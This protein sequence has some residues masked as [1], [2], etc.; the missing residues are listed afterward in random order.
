MCL[1]PEL[2]YVLCCVA[3]NVSFLFFQR[4][5][6]SISNPLLCPPI[7]IYLYVTEHAPTCA[8]PTLSPFLCRLLAY[9]SVPVRPALPSVRSVAAVT[10]PTVPFCPWR[11]TL[12]LPLPR[13]RQHSRGR[14]KLSRS[15]SLFL[16][17]VSPVLTEALVFPPLRAA[18]VIR[19]YR[20]SKAVK[21]IVETWR[22]RSI[23]RWF[24][25]YHGGA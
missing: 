10:R 17:P 23:A 9:P 22:A 12:P 7:C 8:L 14:A 20:Y 3:Q 2:F 25:V 6:P 4:C 21:V 15:K 16:R 13:W 11:L 18:C 19:L 24:G 1:C 5:L